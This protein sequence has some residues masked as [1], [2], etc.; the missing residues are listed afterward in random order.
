MANSTTPV[1]NLGNWTV[2]QTSPSFE[3]PLTRTDANGT[4]SR[5]MDLTGVTT[6]Q[7]SL[8]LYTSAKT[9]ATNSPGTGVFTISNVKPGVVTYAQT[10]ADMVAGVSYLRVKINFSSSSPD[11]SDLISINIQV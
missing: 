9:V 2:G 10:V 1:N 3:L 4:I 6:N 11:F 8:I 7:L 5:V